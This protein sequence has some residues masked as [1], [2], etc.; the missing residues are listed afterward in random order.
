[1]TPDGKRFQFVTAAYLT[2]IENQQAATVRELKD[3][4][5]HASDAAI[6]YHTFQ[7]FGRYHFLS[8]GFTNDFAH[9]ALTSANQTALGERLASID[10]R[11]YLS[12]AEVRSNICLMLDEFVGDRPAAVEQT[13][14]EPF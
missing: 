11:D 13:A 4:V 7:C 2:R 3:G 5:E 8:D 6:F 9:W 1:M 12:I 10:I 14:F